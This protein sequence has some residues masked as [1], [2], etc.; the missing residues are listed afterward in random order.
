M[1]AS[2]CCAWPAHGGNM[3]HELRGQASAWYIESNNDDT[4]RYNVG[5]RYIPYYDVTYRIDDQRLLGLDISLN[6]FA[7]VGG[8]DQA[9]TIDVEL[10]RLKLRYATAQ[11]ETRIGL[12]KIAFG[13]AYVLRSLMWFDRIDPRDPLQLTEGVYGLRFTYVTLSNASLWLW[14]LYGNDEPRGYDLLPS[15]RD[16]PE[17]GGRLQYPMPRG[18]AAFTFHTRQADGS[19][20]GIEDFTEN[21]FALDGRW[22]IEIGFWFESVLQQ[23]RAELIPLPWTKFFTVGIDYTLGIGNGLYIL[24]EHM[25]VVLSSAALGSDEAEHASAYMLNYPIGYLDRLSA[26]GFYSWD[27][28]RYHQYLEWQRTWDLLILSISAFYNTDAE[29]GSEFFER[30]AFGSGYGGRIMLILNH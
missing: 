11:T 18:S 23:Q 12:Q 15:V 22:D 7:C 6:A 10:Y 20:Y 9:D 26:I 29:S 5:L 25:A 17:L 21:R 4:R 14:G 28:E 13:P 2:T 24:L 1:L 30:T 3:E 16:A 19:V 27:N 8:G